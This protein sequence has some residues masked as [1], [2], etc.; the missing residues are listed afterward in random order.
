MKEAHDH[1]RVTPEGRTMGEETVA[2]YDKA[3]AKLG[4]DAD[5][6]ERCKTCAFRAGTVPNGCIQTQMDVMKCVVENT[7]FYCHQDL[8]RIC[9]G[10]FT[11]RCA[12]KDKIPAGATVP[13]EMSP[14]DSAMPVLERAQAKRD[15]RAAKRLKLGGSKP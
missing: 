4:D 5:P 13:W 15:R 6:D 7:P 9:H 14:P 1:H 12:L 10:W 2:L 3:E 11:L 8:K